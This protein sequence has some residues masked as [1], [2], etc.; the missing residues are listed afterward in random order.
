MS[1]VFWVNEWWWKNH[2]VPATS[3]WQAL[4]I[5]H[6]SRMVIYNIPYQGSI[7]QKYAN[8]LHRLENTTKRGNVYYVKLY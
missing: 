4:C 1:I 8:I 6:T 7:L 2:V 3:R 5:R